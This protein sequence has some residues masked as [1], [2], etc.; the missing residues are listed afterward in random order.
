MARSTIFNELPAFNDD[1]ESLQKVRERYSELLNQLQCLLDEVHQIDQ[2]YNIVLDHRNFIGYQYK[3]DESV[4][5][6][7]CDSTLWEIAFN[8][9]QIE[10]FITNKDKQ[11]MRDKYH[12]NPPKFTA[13]GGRD[14][15]KKVE[16][17]SGDLMMDAVKK[18]YDQI[19]QAGYY[20]RNKGTYQR[21]HVKQNESKMKKSFRIRFAPYRPFGSWLMDDE[22]NFVNDLELACC[23]LTGS[24]KPD[25]PNRAGDKVKDEYRKS[26]DFIELKFFSMKIFKNGNAVIDLNDKS[27]VDLFNQHGPTSNRLTKG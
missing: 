1:M 9:S 6:K 2:Q 20:R 23:M 7:R 3:L 13:Q 8:K 12:E 11:E 19:T 24:E 16:N 25:Y 18:I 27:L 5:M 4:L 22:V 26:N 10:R 15:I 21:E 17:F 14:L